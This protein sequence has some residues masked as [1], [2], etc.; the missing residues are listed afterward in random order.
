MTPLFTKAELAQ[1]RKPAD[2]DEWAIKMAELFGRT[3]ENRTY[4]GSGALLPKK[5]YDEVLPLA[6][7]AH[8][9]YGKC[10]NVTVTPN[11]GNEG[12]DAA[13]TVEAGRPTRTYIE[14]T[15]AKDGYNEALRLEA[16]TAQGFSNLT[17][18][19]S[20]K[21][22]KGRADRHIIVE[23]EAIRHVEILRH[24]LELVVDRLRLKA[25]AK[26]GQDHVLLVVVDDYLAFRQPED[27]AALNE[28]AQKELR[29]L[30][31]DFGRVVFMGMG[32]RLWLSFPGAE[33]SAP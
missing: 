28:L 32:Q 26:Y 27:A 29:D 7:F 22:R 4:A 16:L 30:Q 19:V 24:N 12:F 8:Q 5:F 18:R 2:L 20:R 9:E 23:N 6:L 21:G 25:R 3:P 10:Q 15:Y 11:L 17:G 1:S 14:I 33:H 13:I 31:L